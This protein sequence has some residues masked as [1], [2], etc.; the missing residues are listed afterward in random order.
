MYFLDDLVGTLKMEARS[1]LW[2]MDKIS[3]YK[4]IGNDLEELNTPEFFKIIYYESVI[5][6][7]IQK[8]AAQIA[9][10][11]VCILII[12]TSVTSQPRRG[13]C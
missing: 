12:F 10:Y 5:P 9:K 4:Y 7:D 2:S 8:W 11:E 6:V 1:K 3:S 13:K